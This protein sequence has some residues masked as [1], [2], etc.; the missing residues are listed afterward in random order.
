MKKMLALLT[1]TGAAAFALNVQAATKW[2]LPSAYPASN[3]HT[4]N[5]EQFA[6]D[7]S[8]LSGGELDIT[9]ELVVGRAIVADVEH[10]ASMVVVDPDGASAGVEGARAPSPPR[11]RAAARIVPASCRR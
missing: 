1:A 10:D 11:A 3:L 6:K 9:D 2:D 7:V 5:L 8:K 4:Q